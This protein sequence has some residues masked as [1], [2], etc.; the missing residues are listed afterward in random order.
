M[1]RNSSPLPSGDLAPM[2]VCICNALKESQIHEVVRAGVR[3]EREAYRQLGCRPQCG[4]CL[5]VARALVKGSAVQ[6]A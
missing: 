4:V 5:P 3:C 6:P 1:S 2:Y